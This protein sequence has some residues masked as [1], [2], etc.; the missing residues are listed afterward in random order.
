M[1]TE[2]EVKPDTMFGLWLDGVL[3]DTKIGF[4]RGRAALTPK[5]LGIPKEKVP[6]IFTL[7]RKLTVPPEAIRVLERIEARAHYVTDQFTFPF[8][9]RA[10]F[11]PYSVLPKILEELE[12]L[13]GQFK[14]AVDNFIAN[15]DQYRSDMFERYPEFREALEAAY[16][17]AGDLRKKYHFDWLLY[18]V[19]M[20]KVARMKE[21]AVRDAKLEAAA[22]GNA[23]DVASAQFRQ[24]FSQQVDDFLAGAVGKLRESVG[25]KV[26]Q[27]SAQVQSGKAVSTGSLDAVKRVIEQFKNLNFVGDVGVANQLDALE[28]LIPDSN[29]RFDETDFRAAFQVALNDVS[30]TVV[31]SDISQ[32]T[33]EYK[34]R[35]RK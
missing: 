2:V 17:G 35:V 26:A 24:E 7:G 29:K 23:L 19:S 27:L 3:I 20:P 16:V 18:E 9:T 13:G 22:R 11:V 5:D 25:E 15:Y 8:P 31:E 32:I 4:W 10:R 14:T 34:R 1:V 12:I 28:K 21:I 6:D 33:G 30:K